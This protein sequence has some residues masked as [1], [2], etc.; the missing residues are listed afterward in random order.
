MNTRVIA[1]TV[2]SSVVALGAGG[3]GVFWHL[4]RQKR[5]A[6]YA[7]ALGEHA[8]AI[9]AF[10][11]QLEADAPGLDELEAEL[12]KKEAALKRRE[13]TM[14]LTRKQVLTFKKTM[15][16]RVARRSSRYQLYE[17]RPRNRNTSGT[18]H[19][20]PYDLELHGDLRKLQA[21]LRNLFAHSKAMQVDKIEVSLVE[22]GRNACVVKTSIRIFEHQTPEIPGA[23]PAGN[24]TDY[25]R[26]T[27]AMPL[28]KEWKNLRSEEI[29]SG[30]DQVEAAITRLSEMADVEARRA[31]LQRRQAAL[32]AWEASLD[33]LIARRDANRD[34]LVERAPEIVTQVRESANG[35][36][37]ANLEEEGTKLVFK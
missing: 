26:Y 18:V 1:V 32:E 7:E 36:I 35:L 25:E 20:T 6:A 34:T 22:F 2:A 19:D 31:A 21:M 3:G 15:R 10:T 37:V 8:A 13:R 16:A 9:V 29:E 4:S 28:P 14:N 30:H 5:K 12:A 17:M 27:A 11:D 23:E 33:A 24:S